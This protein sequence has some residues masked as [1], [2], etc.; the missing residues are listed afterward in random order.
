[1]GRSE[2]RPPSLVHDRDSWMEPAALERAAAATDDV[3]AALGSGALGNRGARDAGLTERA[4]GCEG[5]PAVQGDGF[6]SPPYCAVLHLAADTVGLE[7]HSRGRWYRVYVEAH[8]RFVGPEG[9]LGERTVRVDGPWRPL[10]R[11][12]ADDGAELRRRAVEAAAEAGARLAG[13]I[14]PSEAAAPPWPP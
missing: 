1:M 13:E 7:R 3:R 11:L 14:S 4:G 12:T 8:G 10:E 2:E 5:L 6:A 9:V